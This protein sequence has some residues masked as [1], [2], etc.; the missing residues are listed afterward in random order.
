M[1]KANLRN[2]LGNLEYVV[3]YNQLFGHV[4]NIHRTGG[5]II[6]ITEVA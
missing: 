5:K 1:Q 3:N 6:S 2:R 4:K